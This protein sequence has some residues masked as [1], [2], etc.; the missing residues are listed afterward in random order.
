[1]TNSEAPSP[2]A[3]PAQSH[4]KTGTPIAAKTGAPDVPAPPQVHVFNVFGSETCRYKE[5]DG[6]FLEKRS[7]DSTGVSAFMLFIMFASPSVCLGA[8]FT[9]NTLLGY[10]WGNL[11]VATFLG[12]SCYLCF[13]LNLIE[14][15]AM[16]PFN[17]GMAVFARAAFGPYVGYFVGSCEAWEYILVAGEAFYFFGTTCS[18]I[19]NTDEKFAPLYWIPAMF[20][21]LGAHYAGV[22]YIARICAVTL[23][24]EVVGGFCIVMAAMPSYNLNQNAI[25]SAAEFLPADF[26]GT[27]TTYDLLFPLGTSGLWMSTFSQVWTVLGIEGA[28]LL[29]DESQYFSQAPKL[30]IYAMILVYCVISYVI[31]LVPGLSPGVGQLRGLNDPMIDAF[32]S[33]WNMDLLIDGGTVAKILYS[34][35][36][37]PAL[38]NCMM[39]YTYFTSRQIYALSK[40]GYYPQ[41][42]SKTT[43]ST[44]SPFNA[45]VLACV[46]TVVIALILQFESAGVVGQALLNGSLLYAI[47][48]YLSVS[49]AYIR[50]KLIFPNLKRPFDLGN[51]WGILMAVISLVAFTSALIELFL[52][53]IMRETLFVCLGKLGV[54]T[55]EFV[56]YHRFH[57]ISTPEEEFI[58]KQLGRL[59]DGGQVPEGCIGEDGKIDANKFVHDLS[60]SM[61]SIH[62]SNMSNNMSQNR[63][64]KEFPPG[65]HEKGRS[66]LSAHVLV[67]VPGRHAPHLSHGHL[68]PAH[69]IVPSPRSA[70]LK[71]Q[72]P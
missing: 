44:K 51:F 14:L 68:T 72:S 67:E 15:M 50:M 2:N 34:L 17:G 25:Q 4:M 45:S 20:L 29:A 55:I 36:Y 1:M 69:L 40:V 59:A 11:L 24:L 27:P 64:G 3:Q 58:Q 41:L 21:M 38:I 32:L 57:L 33:T 16:L 12:L 43:E 31:I 54:M 28:P 19:F 48:A 13:V 9:W 10:G 8:P 49:A 65:H 46:L 18:Q 30:M 66:T 35:F 53:E 47:F 52:Q 6:E 70:I 60:A 42:Y 7:L 61:I 56:V 62:R 71:T 5:C 39:C 63:S 23:F 22:K 37:I 26:T